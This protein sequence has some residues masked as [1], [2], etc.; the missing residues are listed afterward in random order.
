MITTVVLAS[1]ALFE[2]VGP[3]GA[4]VALEKAGEARPHEGEPAV[5]LD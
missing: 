5:L 4:R 2:L 3:L 1:V